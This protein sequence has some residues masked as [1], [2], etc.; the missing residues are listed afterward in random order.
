MALGI[1]YTEEAMSEVRGRRRKE[2]ANG[3]P[4]V[5]SRLAQLQPLGPRK[6]YMC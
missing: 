5:A 6:G 2:E 1:P 4:Q 3:Q